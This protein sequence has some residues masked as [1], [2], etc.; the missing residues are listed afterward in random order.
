[1]SAA[2]STPPAP[3]SST[4]LTPKHLTRTE[5]PLSPSD[6]QRMAYTGGALLN[7]LMKRFGITDKDIG[8]GIGVSDTII[9]DLR[10]GKRV[11]SVP[12]IVQIGRMCGP[13]GEKLACA[14][15]VELIRE[16]QSGAHRR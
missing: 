3:S 10:E 15:F 9:G 8:K 1:M 13:D 4:S 11:L 6:E 12:R 5:R 2:K 16:I 7:M 14:L